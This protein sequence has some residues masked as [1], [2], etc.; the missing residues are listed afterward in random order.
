[1]YVLVR[2]LLSD[3]RTCDL[4]ESSSPHHVIH[5]E[6]GSGPLIEISALCT[7]LLYQYN[8]GTIQQMYAPLEVF[9][10]HFAALP[11]LAWSGLRYLSSSSRQSLFVF[12]IIALFSTPQAHV[13]TVWISSV[14]LILSLD[15]QAFT[16]W[17][18]LRTLVVLFVVYLA[19]NSF[20]LLPYVSGV[21]KN[22]KIIQNA[23]INL[24]S[25]DEVFERNKARGDLW[26]VVTMQ[27]YMLDTTEIDVHTK[28]YG[29]LM[30]P[31]RTWLKTP[32]YWVGSVVCMSLMLLGLINAIGQKKYSFVWLVPLLFAFIFLANNTPYVAALNELVRLR[33]PILGEAFR[34]PFTKVITLFMFGQCVLFAYG[35]YHLIRTVKW[36]GV[37]VLISLILISI[38][39]WTGNL[40]ATSVR[41]DLPK[42]YR[43]MFAYMHDRP[44]DMR[45]VLLPAH[46]FWSWQSRTWGYTGSDF[47]WHVTCDVACAAGATHCAL[48][49]GSSHLTR[50]PYDVSCISGHGGCVHADQVH[51]AGAGPHSATGC[52]QA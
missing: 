27:G 14:V 36:F 1:M 32:W 17:R 16:R 22:A 15:L 48:I 12:A 18:S 2:F 13:P 46:T 9:V 43:E 40:F 31:W 41:P 23:R 49:A 4:S 30:E 6:V 38:P 51:S 35:T 28:T 47:I 8:I 45:T 3:K 11:W 7:A 33:A 20:W 52:A 19:V 25:S 44:H 10:F 42:S 50:N 21:S 26:N 5:R 29:F 39:V 34:F 37:L 24:Y